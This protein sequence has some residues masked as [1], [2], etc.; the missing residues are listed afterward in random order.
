MSWQVIRELLEKRIQALE[1]AFPTAWEGKVFQ[2]T[3]GVAHQR[4]ALLPGKPMM[5]P[6]GSDFRVET[7]L[8]QIDLFYPAN[9]GTAASTAKAQ[10]VLAQFARGLSLNEGA[11][12]VRILTHPF[13]SPAPADAAW[14]RAVVSVPFAAEIAP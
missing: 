14:L 10:G 2:P 8:L 1:P 12:T 13:L 9:R 7:G 11:V 6:F 4:V 5:E 3:T